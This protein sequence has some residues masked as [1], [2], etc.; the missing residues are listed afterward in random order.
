M[1]LLWPISELAALPSCG[2]RLTVP[3]TTLSVYDYRHRRK[4][5]L[6]LLQY[7]QNGFTRWLSSDTHPSGRFSVIFLSYSAVESEWRE[8]VAAIIMV[9]ELFPV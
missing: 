6:L 1:R 3:R 9:L 2:L 5:Q 7:A 4:C 8:I